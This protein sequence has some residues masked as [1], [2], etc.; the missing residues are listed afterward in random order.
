ML[1]IRD[2]GW[3]RLRTMMQL[4]TSDVAN[5]FGEHLDRAVE[6]GR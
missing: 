6:G 5:R 3:S 4:E 2:S 1:I